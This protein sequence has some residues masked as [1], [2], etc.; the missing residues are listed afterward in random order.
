M[1]YKKKQIS[2]ELYEFCLKEKW[3]DAMLTAKWKK[4]GYE[5]L[6]SLQT[7]TKSS[8]N[9]GTTSIY[10]VP[11]HLRRPE[12]Q[13]PAVNTG[14]I[15]CSSFEASRIGGPIWWDTNR[16][17]DLVEWA[18]AGCPTATKVG[19]KRK[20]QELEDEED[21]DEAAEEAAIAERAAKLRAE[22]LAGK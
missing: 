18:K 13:T 2:K 9:F 6:C 14:C 11:L 5:F 20:A 7:I 17:A 3:A 10:R 15:S 16:P 12:P 4:P 8:T 1:Y 19:K 22:R 21:E